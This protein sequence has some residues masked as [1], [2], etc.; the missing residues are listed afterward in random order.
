MLRARRQGAPTNRG[1]GFPKCFVEGPVAEP[2]LLSKARRPDGNL[3][4]D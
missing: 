1:D 4:H 3:T 2:I